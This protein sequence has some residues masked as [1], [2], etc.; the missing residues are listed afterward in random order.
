MALL[1]CM[2]I[3]KPNEAQP[4]AAPHSA[5]I[6][7]WNVENLFDTQPDST[8]N[9]YSF[10]PL[11]EKCWTHRRLEHKLHGI[12]RTIAY[13]DAPDV[14]GLAE[15][16]NA[17]VLQHLVQGT[18]LRQHHYQFIHHDSPDRRGIDVALLYRADRFCPLSATYVC[19]SDSA[20]QFFTRDMMVVRGVTASSDTLLLLLCHWPSKLGGSRAAKHRMTIAKRLKCCIDS[21]HTIYPSNAIVVMGDFNSTIDEPPLQLLLSRTDTDSTPNKLQHLTAN[22]P[23]DWGS[24]KYQGTWSYIDHMFMVADGSWQV[25]PPHLVRPPFLLKEEGSRPGVRPHRTFLGTRYEGGISDH[26]PLLI[27]IGKKEDADKH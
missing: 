21:L 12:F 7:W 15:V 27:G 14:V 3:M 26:L 18:P 11:G 10:T 25:S 17:T 9:E 5:S 13:M 16:E 23:H 22:L 24:Y 2:T 1:L 8:L 6:A 20:S 19:N 4:Q